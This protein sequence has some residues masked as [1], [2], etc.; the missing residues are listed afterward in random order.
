MAI[1][2][3]CFEYSIRARA[4]DCRVPKA[5]GRLNAGTTVV[6][7]AQTEVLVRLSIAGVFAAA[8][9]SGCASDPPA[10]DIAAELMA[11]DRAFAAET[12]ARGADGWA[13]FFEIDAVMYESEGIVAGRDAIRDARVSVFDEARMDLR[14]DPDTAIAAASG[15][16]G[17]TLGRWQVYDSSGAPV[18]TGRYVTI[19]HLQPDGSWKIALD[20]GNEDPTPDDTDAP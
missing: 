9:C 4:I 13:S 18:G 17:Y 10:K 11:A 5:D 8:L 7:V 3:S 12:A 14:W 1:A 15:E 16:L 2:Q 6:P 20:I 19:W